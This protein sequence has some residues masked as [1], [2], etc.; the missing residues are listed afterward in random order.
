MFPWSAPLL[1]KPRESPVAL[2]FD[3]V[4]VA[5]LSVEL[6]RSTRVMFGEATSEWFSLG[7]SSM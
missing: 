5:L 6:S 4:T 1:V 2:P 3:M 7:L